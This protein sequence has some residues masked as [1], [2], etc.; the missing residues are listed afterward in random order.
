VGVVD[1]ELRAA[2]IL[3]GAISDS[4]LLPWEVVGLSDGVPVSD[5]PGRSGYRSEGVCPL[6]ISL[7]L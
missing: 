3:A 5:S 1:C 7:H 6:A 2:F 4:L